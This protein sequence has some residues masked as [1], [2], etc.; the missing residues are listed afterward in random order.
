MLDDFR[1][2]LLRSVPQRR[3]DPEDE[4]STSAQL[5][6]ALTAAHAQLAEE[7]ERPAVAVAWER[8]PGQDGVRVLTGGRPFFPPAG[9]DTR[10]GLHPV[11]YPPGAQGE[12]VGLDEVL[13]GWAD[14]PYWVRCPGQPDP[15]WTGEPDLR[16]GGFDDCIAHL[17][18]P[19][20]WLVVA[21]PTPV[22][23]VDH[24][25]AAL[26]ARVPRLRQR[27]NS[28]L[29]RVALERAQGRYRE[30]SRARSTGLWDVHV[31]VG[32]GSAAAVRGAAAVLCS[33]G[34]LDDLPYVL[35]R[36]DRPGSLDHVWRTR[37]ASA[38]QPSSPFPA[39]AD[40]LAA[41][42]RPPRRELPGIRLVERAE[43]DLTPEQAGG[44]A[45]GEIRTDT[46][47][48]AGLF[49]VSTATLNRHTF[50]AG[51]TGAGKS[52]TVRHLLES[53]HGAGV[54]WLVIEPAK[55]EYARMAGRIGGEHVAVLRPGHPGD[56]PAGLNPLQ[57][58]PG[59]P[60]QTHVDLVRELFLAAFEAQEPFPQVLAQALTRCYSELGWD[61]VLGESRIDGV[62]PRHPTLAD[63][64]RVAHD[65]VSGIG[66]G[67]E[68]T[69]NVRGFIDIRVGSLRLGTPGRFFEGPY[70]IDVADLLSHNV[71]LEIEDVGNDQD[72]A[73]FIGT[74]LI[75]LYEHL[76][77][78]CRGRGDGLRHVTVIEEAHR[79]LK[80]VA[81]G[82]PAAHAVE[83]FTSLLAETRAYGE[84]IV[85]AEQ[86]PAKIVPDVVKNTALKIIHRL[87]AGDDRADVGATMNLD[88]A[89][90]R[91][92]AS[93]PPGVAVVFADGMD[94][95]MRVAVP[96]GEAR[97]NASTASRDITVDDATALRLTGGGPYRL[98]ELAL[99]ARTAADPR[100]VVWIELLT[101]AHIVGRPEPTPRRCWL[102]E[103]LGD[104]DR[105]V[106]E[107]AVA[108]RVQAAVTDRYAGL[109][110]YYQPEL[111]AE[112]VARCAL[113]RL[114]DI[115]VACDG[116]ETGW[117]AGR[118]RWTDVFAAL[119][120]AET[121]PPGSHPDTAAWARRGLR[122]TGSTQIEQRRAL[123]RH[124]DSWRPP[125]SI[126][127]G[128]GAC[129]AAVSQITEEI[130]PRPL[131]REATRHLRLGSTWPLSRGP[132]M[133]LG[134]GT[135]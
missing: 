49:E 53:L 93:L 35:L 9:L 135:T 78:H 127:A 64:Q 82:S 79:L 91:Q 89:Q 16:R 117:Q 12:A 45:V 8:R 116:G 114:K 123:R 59:F 70:Q 86:I 128:S 44:I 119:A 20:V 105:G 40:L 90:S 21:E 29:D 71:V 87:P 129:A 96:L 122:L 3:E 85:I 109:V 27:E 130:E 47:T 67:K 100:L 22:A 94:R 56:V 54:P 63:L 43:F 120:D 50:V 80:R 88:E 11:R 58:E 25:L 103:L 36:G 19:F 133:R 28:E 68:I 26:A 74:V 46:D 34:D 1:F 30:L 107:C 24:E 6:A 32:A 121:A 131:L 73:F 38:D 101:V 37:I 33:S 76:R 115:G 125:L 72:K 62:T 124:P 4:R 102:D 99:A 57:P 132:L 118:Y 75:R 48:S 42:A 61:L 17:T 112:H 14:V 95:P 110:E 10:P 18:G 23:T 81:P 39:T 52:Q 66:Y 106:L 65:V 104:T 69:D 41:L 113:D 7:A 31:L 60:L 15:L 108:L 84:G 55:S 97:E 2:H 51:A 83:L 13:G 98:R 5:V 92:V 77:V 134:K 126:L 111:L